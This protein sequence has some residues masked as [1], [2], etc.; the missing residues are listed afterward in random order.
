MLRHEWISLQMFE[1][2]VKK[3]LKDYFKTRTTK[4]KVKEVIRLIDTYAFKCIYH[5]FRIPSKKINANNGVWF[6]NMTKFI[7]DYYILT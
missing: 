7:N 4:I 3:L 1:T 2:E 6:K 5:G